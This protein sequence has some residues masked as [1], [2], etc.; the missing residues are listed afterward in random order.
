MVTLRNIID[1][2]LINK[3]GIIYIIKN[4]VTGK[5]YIGKSIN[6]FKDRYFK[7]AYSYSKV[8]RSHNDELQLDLYEYGLNNFTV[9]ILI[10]NILDDEVLRALEEY[11]ILEYS[12]IFEMYNTKLNKQKK[13]LSEMELKRIHHKGK[14]LKTVRRSEEVKNNRESDLVSYLENLLDTQIYGEI[15][16]EFRTVM[17]N[18]YG[19]ATQV[20]KAKKLTREEVD[21]I[22]KPFITDEVSEELYKI[23]CDRTPVEIEE[24]LK[25]ERNRLIEAFGNS[26]DREQ[27]IEQ[28]SES[29]NYYSLFKGTKRKLELTLPSK[30]KIN[31]LILPYGFELKEAKK[32]ID[33]VRKR[34]W[35]INKTESEDLKCIA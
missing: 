31:K 25:A 18:K 21:N 32:T 5:I 13:I 3:V 11:L 6:S 34:I 24:V 7:S 8:F 26:E 33:G 14:W 19:I 27:L 10:E 1:T 22:F 15:K 28:L 12:N 9:E 16:E 17:G 20:K 23:V 29:K 2:E 30:T 4:I 35:I